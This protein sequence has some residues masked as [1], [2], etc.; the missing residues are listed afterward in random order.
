LLLGVVA[1]SGQTILRVDA[2]V[3]PGGDGSTWAAAFN[4]LQAALQAAAVLTGQGQTVELWVAGGTYRP[5]AGTANRAARFVLQNDIALY[6]GFIGI[7]T[8]REQRDSNPY[9][10]GTALSGDLLGDDGPAFTNRLDNSIN[11]VYTTGTDATAVLDGFRVHGGYA[12][13][14]GGAGLYLRN[15]QA[16]VRN[17]AIEDCW[18]LT[19]GGGALVLADFAASAPTL[20]GCGFNGNAATFGGG[21]GMSQSGAGILA[22]PSF[23]DC[24]IAGN[25]ATQAGGGVGGGGSFLRVAILQNAAPEGGGIYLQRGDL[26]LFD[27]DVSDNIASGIGGGICLARH[28]AAAATAELAGVRVEDNDASNGAGLYANLTFTMTEC[29]F[30]RNVASDQGGA[31]LFDA[32]VQ[33]NGEHAV[34]TPTVDT[35]I[36]DGNSAARGGAVA[37]IHSARATFTGCRFLSNA[38]TGRGGAIDTDWQGSVFAPQVHVRWSEFVWN[39]AAIGGAAYNYA[40]ASYLGCDFRQNSATNN[41]GAVYATQFFAP[42]FGLCRFNGNVAGGDGG[43]IY[44]INSTVFLDNCLLAGNRAG[45]LGG[46][47]AGATASSDLRNC[48]ITGNQSGGTFG[49]GVHHPGLG[50]SVWNS[51]VWG[52]SPERIFAAGDTFHGLAR[53]SCIAGGAPGAGVFDANPHFTRP[54]TDGGDGFGD[55]PGTP[56]DEG[57]NDD[58]GDLILQAGSPC[59]DAGSNADAPPDRLDLDGD[60]DVGEPLPMDLGLE[61]RFLDDPGMPDIGLGAPPLIDIGAHEFQRTSGLEGDANCDGRLDF[62]DIDP[63]VLALFD[64]PAYQAAFPAC[65]GNADVN[66]DGGVNFFDIDPFVQCVMGGCP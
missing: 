4:D 5:D 9:T 38:A 56:Q 26:V 32:Y 62:F 60:A 45:G 39:T 15:T 19:S 16:T 29:Q 20:D 43:A 14:T 21:V 2:D 31:M 50:L 53:Y 46:G 6:G 58:Y 34:V 35:L 33:Q 61:P 30:R 27:C 13:G 47:L 42:V 8:F 28:A 1:A 59:I 12:S 36:V 64:L 10:N 49:G 54:P 24:S 41:G 3:A 23:T 44:N 18:A 11:V 52:N 63:F 17:C 55:Q 51:A 48:T 65:A 25:T 66:G 7:E 40:T 22:S 37:V 57:S